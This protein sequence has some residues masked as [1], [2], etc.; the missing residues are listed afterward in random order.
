MGEVGVEMGGVVYPVNSLYSTTFSLRPSARKQYTLSPVVQGFTGHVEIGKY[1]KSEE[2]LG[3]YHAGSCEPL[4]EGH[5]L[6]LSPH[7][8]AAFKALASLILKHLS[9][10]FWF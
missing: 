7:P 2:V 5:G 8:S 10:G 6:V 4:S 1:R 3:S 9:F